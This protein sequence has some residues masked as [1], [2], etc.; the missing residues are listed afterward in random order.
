MIPYDRLAIPRLWAPMTEVDSEDEE[1][2]T[3][4]S[5][6]SA[7]SFLDKTLQVTFMVP[8]PVPSDWR[9][10]L[11]ELLSEAFPTHKDFD[12]VYSVFSLHCPRPD[13]TPRELKL[14]V[15]GIGALHRQW[16]DDY[17]L[18]HMAYC[19]LMRRRPG[20][21]FR[22]D[23]VDGHIPDAPS[24]TVLGANAVE[25][26]AVFLFNVESRRA[27]ELLL[28]ARITNALTDETGESLKGLAETHPDGFWTVLRALVDR[29]ETHWDTT[30]GLCS[31][32]I[33]LRSS[34]LTFDQGDGAIVAQSIWQHAVQL[35]S[36]EPLSVQVQNGLAALC[37]IRKPTLENAR[38]IVK[39]V[40]STEGA[41]RGKNAAGDLGGGH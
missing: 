10:F 32:A 8:P 29:N 38:G 23:L 16:Q 36:W 18:S 33:S 30:A 24:R 22:Q 6:D 5:E 41:D 1:S 31:S 21:D 28:S 17:P 37:E 34:S 26:L 4:A 2:A 35:E 40:A 11:I 3:Q 15:N 19:F 39:A 13:P 27:M 14:F 7:G 20:R 25:S 12:P 9:K